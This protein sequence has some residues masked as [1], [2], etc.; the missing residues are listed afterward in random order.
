MK[1]NV[2]RKG[3]VENLIEGKDGEVRGALLKVMN[4]GKVSFIRRPLQKLIPFE[5]QREE[6]QKDDSNFEIV[7][8]V[9]TLV[10]KQ[11]RPKR[12]RVVPNRYGY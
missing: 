5:V 9:D 12:N 2:W 6:E 1:R 4:A 7:S 8:G 11:C 10:R 3:K